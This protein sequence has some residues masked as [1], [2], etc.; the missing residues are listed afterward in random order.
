MSRKSTINWY[1]FC[2]YGAFHQEADTAKI[3]L[4]RF[5]RVHPDWEVLGLVRGDL[6]VRPPTDPDGPPFLACFIQGKLKPR[7]DQENGA[8]PA[9]GRKP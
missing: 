8:L 6:I 3:A 1:V 2:P 4:S 9:G 7:P 5:R